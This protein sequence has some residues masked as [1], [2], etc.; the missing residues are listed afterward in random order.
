MERYTE[1]CSDNRFELIKKYKERLI[2]ATNIETAKD[3]MNVIDSILF[4]F[5]QMGWLDRLEAD[6]VQR[7]EVAR[8]IINLANE[9]LKELT[10]NTELTVLE[11]K[12]TQ[13]GVQL[14]I[15]KIEKK[16]AGEQP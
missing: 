2:E 16:Y 10:D 11:K 12:L 9:L 5:W 8:E 4:R 15:T 6:V 3:E 7:S 1:Q 14:V 13:A